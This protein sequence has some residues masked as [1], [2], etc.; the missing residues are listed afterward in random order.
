[1][2]R[3]PKERAPPS[4][5]SP[6][7]P[8]NIQLS[9]HA[10]LLVPVGLTVLACPASAVNLPWA[11][12]A[13]T[14]VVLAADSPTGLTA[15]H[16]SGQTFLTWQAAT[17][18]QSY[19]VYRDDQPITAGTLG[20]AELLYE[21]QSGS[22]NFYADR[23]Y[24]EATDTWQTRYLERFVIE[25][26]GSELSASTELLVWTLAEEDLGSG[27]TGMG[28]YAVTSVDGVGT[29][30]IGDID[31]S[32]T[33]GPVSESIDTP[34]PV[35]AMVM[36]T[37]GALIFTQF[38]DLRWFNPTLNAPNSYNDYY[39]LD[40]ND[41]EVSEA[42]Q[43]AFNYAV[44]QPQDG[45]C[46]PS[47]NQAPVT[48]MLHGHG[49]HKAR[50]LSYDPD[51]TWCN[52]Y[53]I[54]PFD[55]A[56]SWWFGHAKSHDYRTG[57]APQAGDVIKNYTEQRVLMMIE[58]LLEHPVHGDLSDE[59]R[60]YVYGTS[61][62]GSGT[63]SMS[64]RYPQVFAAAHASQPMTNYSTSGDGGGTDWR[65]DVSIKFGDPS[66]ALPFEVDPEGPYQSPL[67][68]FSGMSVWEWQ[69]H[70]DRLTQDP[71]AVRVPF[72][73]DHGLKDTVIEWGTQGQPIYP[74]L[75]AA[76]LCWAGEIIDV[77]HQNSHMA[78]L[79]QGFVHDFAQPFWGFQ[80]RKDES[81]PGF[82]QSTGN[83][84]LPPAAVG[85]YNADIDWSSS[86]KTIDGAPL[87]TAD[88][89]A[90]TLRSNA[91]NQVVDVLPRRTQNFQPQ[92]GE[93]LRFESQRL[94]NAATLQVGTVTVEDDGRVIVPG[95]WVSTAG[96]RLVLERSLVADSSTLS[97]SAGGS[98]GLD[99]AFG[100][101]LAGQL[102]F[103][104]GSTSGTSPGVPVELH[105]LPLNVDDYTLLTLSQPNS[106]F[107][108]PS[109]SF[110]G[111]DGRASLQFSLPAGTSSSLSGLVVNH[112]GLLFDLQ[113]YGLLHT[114]PAT[115]LT[116]TP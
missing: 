76:G 89:W 49:G 72:G 114:T 109:L 67:I 55:I 36:P 90:M 96:T 25:D 113:G 9:I 40:A 29:E 17:G 41:S 15:V 2:P 7:T 30:N 92:P 82:R 48:V 32:N 21:V 104:L 37:S 34:E 81:V 28:Y 58:A 42:I 108:S 4:G 65:P 44:F 111:G 38:M 51:P 112:A 78:T 22:A 84:A 91:S 83:S 94:S 53:R 60:V 75:D 98:Q 105:T 106:T 6:T 19:R 56:N 74:I 63:L 5:L 71:A 97:L 95:V 62:G 18:A 93:V 13:S 99:L 110:L 27:G 59:E 33:V 31:S 69:N 35:L 24:S 107:L 11:S 12:A 80:A 50:P 100:S 16:R 85:E 1:M 26:S 73:I 116:L 45:V 101:E 66:L 64:M 54:Y 88:M 103:V 61:M 87:D 39:G 3:F 77:A 43:Y 68:A 20:A 79:P 102:Y 23:Y 8:L 70:Q 14:P 86:W 47:E 115:S 46:G 57:L 10:G 52:S